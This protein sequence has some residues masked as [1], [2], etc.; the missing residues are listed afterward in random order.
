M[1]YTTIQSTAPDSISVVDS[2]TEKVLSEKVWGKSYIDFLYGKGKSL[3]FS[4]FLRFFIVQSPFASRLWGI[5]ND[6]ARTKQ[7]IA[8]FC[9]DYNID[10]SEFESDLKDF[11]CFNDFFTRR[12]SKNARPINS[13]PSSFIA[14]ADARYT[15]IPNLDAEMPFTIKG[16]QFQLSSFLKDSLEAKRY[17]GGTLIIARLCPIDCHRYVFPTEGSIIHGPKEIKGALYSVS[18]LAT[19]TF[20]WIWWENKRVISTIK[21]S[22]QISYSMVEVGATNCGTIVQTF[23][24][25]S[26]VEKGMEKGFFKLGGSAIILIIPKDCLQLDEKLISLQKEKQSEIYCQYGQKLGSLM[27]R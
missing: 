3:S 6:M 23:S 25:T 7:K 19:R 16:T 5:Y 18:P 10:Q 4:S 14:P 2:R 1:T 20:P 12:L 27:E 8:P 26:P 13:E 15:F 9:H 24:S 11:T 17:E 22:S 21:T